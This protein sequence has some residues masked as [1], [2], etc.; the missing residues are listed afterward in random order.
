MWI[1]H[2]HSTAPQKN[3]KN[4]F[5]PRKNRKLR[6]CA[7]KWRAGPFRLCIPEEKGPQRP[8]HSTPFH[9]PEEKV[10]SFPLLRGTREPKLGL[11]QQDLAS[12][13]YCLIHPATPMG[14][15]EKGT[16][17]CSRLISLLINNQWLIHHPRERRRTSP[18]NSGHSLP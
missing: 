1:L 6:R 3:S 7:C 17:P 4:H 11:S 12:V 10:W 15:G 9:R 5:F 16:P 13:N 2:C 8:S 14:D 18:A